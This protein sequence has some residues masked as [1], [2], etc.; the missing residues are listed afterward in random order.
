MIEFRDDFTVELVSSMGDDSSIVK[1]MLVSTLGS[2]SIEAEATQGRIDYLMRNRHGSP[3]EHG[4]M[5]FLVEAP[6]FVFREWHRHRIG[7]SYNEVSGRYSEM[8]PC[9]Y[10][11][12]AHRP[13]VQVGKPGHYTFV[14]GTSQQYKDEIRDLKIDS[15][16]AYN[17]YKISLERGIA[18]EVSRMRLPLNLFS[19]MYV[20]CNPR[21]MMSFLSLRTTEEESTFPSYPMWEIEQCGRKMESI[22]SS[23]Y[24]LTHKSFRV[25]G[26]VS[27]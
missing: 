13:L 14:P 23:L 5:T 27:P 22:F 6:I 9:F 1:A 4:A 10:I 11:P 19:S 24:P 2:D 12:P 8:K 17:S 25:N 26:S 3:F 15:V 16:Q 21:S 20:T 18:K 7:F